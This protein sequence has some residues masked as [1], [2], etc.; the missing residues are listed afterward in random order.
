MS[1]SGQWIIGLST[2][3]YRRLVSFY[4]AQFRDVFGE[5]MIALFDDLCRR[6]WR[7]SGPA[8]MAQLWVQTSRD[9][10]RT[11]VIEYW[12]EWRHTMRWKD[13]VATTVGILLLLYAFSF[14]IVNILIYN[15]G[16]ASLWNPFDAF[17]NSAQPTLFSQAMEALLVVSPALAMAFLLIPSL[18]L[19]VD[20]Q[21]EAWATIRVRRGSRLTLAL[22]G[23][24]LLAGLIFVLY[25]VGENLGCLFN[26][27]AV[28]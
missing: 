6:A 17:L 3:V 28:C 16:F 22:I 2:R 15:L 19:H 18:E 5:P 12:S 11:L 13:G 21:S 23:L 7:R 27:Q 8:G 24:C 25:L 10:L 14:A 20:L 9:L 4:P 1:G 26:Q